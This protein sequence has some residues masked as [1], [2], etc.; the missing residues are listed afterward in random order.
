MP[1]VAAAVLPVLQHVKRMC[2]DDKLQDAVLQV[3][4][5]SGGLKR[6]RLDCTALTNLEVLQGSTGMRSG[7]LLDVL[8]TCVSVSG[9]R[10]IRAWLSQP[11]C[12]VDAIMRRQNAV[13]D[14]LASSEL[15]TT[16]TDGLR[17]LPDMDRCGHPTMSSSWYKCRSSDA[18]VTAVHRVCAR[19]QCHADPSCNLR[20]RSNTACVRTSRVWPTGQLR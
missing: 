4:P 17:G 2:L 15:M 1:A 13:R 14:I 6:M 7:S 9:K 5:L 10:L 8:D 16:I 20:L 19:R 11:L 3:Q 18:C 12:D